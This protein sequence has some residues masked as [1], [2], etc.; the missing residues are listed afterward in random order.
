MEKK[1]SLFVRIGGMEA[2]NAAVEIFYQKVLADKVINHFF[3]HIDMNA[4]AGKM[5]T[6]LAYAFGAPMAHYS[7]KKMREAHAHM[8]LTEEHFN[9]VAN[10]LVATLN[11]LNVPQDMIDEVVEIAI[12]TKNDV[13]NL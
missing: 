5:K 10:N 1:E 12:S 4:Q 11:E 6:F 2:V 7:G 9:A 13:L 8:N 3:E